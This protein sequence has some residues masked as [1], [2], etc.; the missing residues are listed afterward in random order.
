MHV[1]LLSGSPAARSRTEVLLDHVRQ[2]LQTQQ[3][4]VSLLRVLKAKAQ[5]E[6]D[7]FLL[8]QIR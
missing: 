3:V 4:D 8:P 2:R 5:E 7:G 6:L 1:V